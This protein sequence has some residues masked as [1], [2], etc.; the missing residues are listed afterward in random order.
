MDSLKM[1]IKIVVEN[2]ETRLY[3]YKNDFIMGFVLIIPYID[4]YRI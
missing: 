1:G 2:M 3:H 4:M